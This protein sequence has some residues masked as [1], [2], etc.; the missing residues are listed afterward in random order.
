LQGL[1]FDAADPYFTVEDLLDA[2]EEGL[3]TE[4]NRQPPPRPR[5][6]DDAPPPENL[7]QDP[8]AQVLIERADQLLA[9][10]DEVTVAQLLADAGD[11][12]SSRRVLSELTAIHLHSE[13]PFTLRWGDGLRVDAA[14]PRTWVS[15]GWFARHA[16]A[17]RPDE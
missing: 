16:T 15:D 5:V 6:D 1:L 3:H 8:E 9:G 7:D 4:G 10:R 12:P 13:L 11:W 2:V 14:S 17:G